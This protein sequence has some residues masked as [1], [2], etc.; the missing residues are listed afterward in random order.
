LVIASAVALAVEPAS[1][2]TRRE[3]EALTMSSSRHSTL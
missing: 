2:P 3:R 1:A